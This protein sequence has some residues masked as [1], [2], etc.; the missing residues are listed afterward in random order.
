[1][2]R[3]RYAVYAANLNMLVELWDENTNEGINACKQK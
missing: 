1:M 3:E 2:L